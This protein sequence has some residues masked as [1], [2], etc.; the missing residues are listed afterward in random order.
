[1]DIERTIKKNKYLKKKQQANNI[2]RNPFFR[3]P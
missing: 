2:K 1:M 3:N